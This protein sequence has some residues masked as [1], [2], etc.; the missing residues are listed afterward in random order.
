MRMRRKVGMKKVKKE[1]RNR[2]RE[3]KD[4]GKESKG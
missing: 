4:R 1:I 2:D 3:I